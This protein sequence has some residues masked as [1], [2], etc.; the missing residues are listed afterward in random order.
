M[1]RIQIGT[2]AYTGYSSIFKGTAV[3]VIG[4]TNPIA[5]GYQAY[6]VGS[7]E[8][9]IVNTTGAVED[10]G[11]ESAGV[12]VTLENDDFCSTQIYG[13][14]F[15]ADVT[16]VSACSAIDLISVTLSPITSV[17]VTQDFSTSLEFGELEYIYQ[18]SE[19]ACNAGDPTIVSTAP[20]SNS[21]IGTQCYNYGSAGYLTFNPNVITSPSDCTD[22][23]WIYTAQL[24][25]SSVDSPLPSNI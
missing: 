4:D 21:G 17:E 6:I 8:D 14:I 5:T 12:W 15:E 18:Q 3:G 23:F 10:F 22:P 11:I 20:G 1:Q 24:D 9:Y 13:T 16:G 25:A 7:I 19:A 2:A